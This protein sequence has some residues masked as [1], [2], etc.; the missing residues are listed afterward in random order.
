MLSRTEDID[1]TQGMKLNVETDYTMKVQDGVM[2]SNYKNGDG[3]KRGDNESVIEP[4]VDDITVGTDNNKIV[5]K[6]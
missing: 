2:S 3:I 5:R 1:G 4:N 6:E